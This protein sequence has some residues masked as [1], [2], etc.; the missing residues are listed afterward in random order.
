MAS[1]YGS[2]PNDGDN[3]WRT[4]GIIRR[5]FRASKDGP[6]EL[7]AKSLG[8]KNKKKWCKGKKGVEHV[9]VEKVSRT[10]THRNATTTYYSR[11]CK[12][13]SK[14]IDFWHR[15]ETRYHACGHL[16][17]GTSWYSRNGCPICHFRENYISTT[18]RYRAVRQRHGRSKMTR[19]WY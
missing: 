1:V 19:R 18:A 7:P 16:V 17:H 10:Y 14:Q 11:V 9:L 5:D 2:G 12:N 3:K 4:R 8:K 15:R 13:C 6:E